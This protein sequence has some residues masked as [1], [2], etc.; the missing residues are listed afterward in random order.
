MPHRERG[1]RVTEG[2][3]VVRAL[4]RDTPGQLPGPLHRSSRASRSIPSPCRSRDRPSGS[5]AAPTPRSTRAGRQGDGWVSYVV[6]P[7]RYAQS[8][9]KIRRGRGGRA[10]AR[11]LRRRAPRASSPWAATARR[12]KAA[13]VQALCPSATRRTSSRSPASTGSSARPSS[14]PSSSRASEAAGCSYIR[15]EP[16]RRSRGRARAARAR[17]PPTSCLCCA[18][19]ALERT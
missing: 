11:R 9:A 10:L 4:W 19:G 3:D 7:E 15:H 8:L 2:I 18:P 1:A 6:Q 5:A 12:R 17:S 16:H 13:W 14:A